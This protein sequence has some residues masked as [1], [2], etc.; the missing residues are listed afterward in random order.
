MLAASGLTPGILM[1]ENF[2]RVRP[3]R[4]LDGSS[5]PALEQELGRYIDAGDRLFVIDLSTVEFISS[6]GLRVLMVV[7]KRVKAYGGRL[8]LCAVP[9]PIREALDAVGYSLIFDV[10]QDYEEA[11]AHLTMR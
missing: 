4:R 10:F 5:S 11:V 9:M 6:A 1:I 7:A 2:R 8:V 3:P